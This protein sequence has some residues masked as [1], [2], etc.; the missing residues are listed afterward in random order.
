M[1]T[2]AGFVRALIRTSKVFAMPSAEL[3]EKA[4]NPLGEGNHAQAALVTAVLKR[5][6]GSWGAG[7]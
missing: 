5:D 3:E 1:V 6:S 2:V 4:D 7:K